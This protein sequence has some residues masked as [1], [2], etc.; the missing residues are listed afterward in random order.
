MLELVWL[1][2]VVFLILSALFDA[3][4]INQ[5]DFNQ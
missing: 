3:M 2:M 4:F 1:V 5:K